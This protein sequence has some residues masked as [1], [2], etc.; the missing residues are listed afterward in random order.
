[1]KIAEYEIIETW[2]APEAQTPRGEEP[3]HKLFKQGMRF[4]GFVN[5]PEGQDL[6]PHVIASN[7]W[8]IPLKFTRKVGELKTKK[9]KRRPNSAQQNIMALSASGPEGTTLKKE[10]LPPGIRK[11]VHAIGDGSLGNKTKKRAGGGTMGGLIGGGI[12]TGYALLTGRR[13]F[14]YAVMG[15]LAGILVGRMIGG[16]VIKQTTDA[17]QEEEK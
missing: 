9:R 14:G 15:I 10:D 17:Q 8:V 5:E 1:M 12:G 13:W 6:P 16:R 11:H 4:K 7:R 2:N 3:Q